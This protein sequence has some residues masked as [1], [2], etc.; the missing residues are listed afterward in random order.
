MKYLAHHAP[1]SCWGKLFG[2][3]ALTGLLAGCGAWQ[4]AKVATVNTTKAIFVADTLTLKLDLVGRAG[5]NGDDKEQPMSVAVRVYQLDDGKGFEAAHYDMLL[6]DD[7]SVLK[8]NLLARKEFILRPGATISLNEPLDK[9]TQSVGV[10][11]FFRQNGKDMS[12][13]L[14]IPRADLSD[15]Q[16]LRLEAIGFALVRPAPTQR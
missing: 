15:K 5:M 8:S 14:S 13:R 7:T 4:T 16:P 10:A 2:G 9:A 11:A 3:L 1:T 12:W 6:A